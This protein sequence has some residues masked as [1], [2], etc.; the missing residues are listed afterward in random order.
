MKNP[1]IP[2]ALAVQT[3]GAP[4][5]LASTPSSPTHKWT[6]NG[7]PKAGPGRPQPSRS[8]L[9][10]RPQTTGEKWSIA[11]DQEVTWTLSLCGHSAPSSARTPYKSKDKSKYSPSAKPPQ[12]KPNT[13]QEPIPT[14]SDA[15]NESLLEDEIDLDLFMNQLPPSGRHKRSAV[16]RPLLLQ[17]PP[18]PVATPST[19][20]HLLHHLPPRKP[21]SSRKIGSASVVPLKPPSPNNSAVKP[22]T[23]A[24]LSS[25]EWTVVQ[26][27]HACWL[28]S[29]LKQIHATLLSEM[30]SIGVPEGLIC[31]LFKVNGYASLHQQFS[32]KLL[33]QETADMTPQKEKEGA[34]RQAKS[35][36]KPLVYRPLPAAI[37]EQWPR[38]PDDLVQLLHLL[39][40][41]NKQSVDA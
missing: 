31:H 6:R 28:K 14:E 23:P 20:R 1:R 25:Y 40:P 32:Q 5:T 33:Q 35:I 21:V 24:S 8:G 41:L 11:I 15:F 34:D 27:L 12:I 3:V 4:P 9:H 18:P 19:L 2:L 17:L 30:E 39:E 10:S 13:L 37:K 36:L 22:E 7:R 29:T 16:C 26:R 38:V